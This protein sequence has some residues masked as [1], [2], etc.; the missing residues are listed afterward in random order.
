MKT[1]K[2]LKSRKSNVRGITITNFKLYYRAITIKNS[3]IL[4]QKQTGRAMDQNRRPS[5][6]PMYT[7]PTDL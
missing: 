6:K 5:H 1:Q 2:T 3:I 4:A 7:Q